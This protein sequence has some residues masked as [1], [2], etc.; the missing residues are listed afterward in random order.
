MIQ[1]FLW[2]LF[3]AWCGMILYAA[4]LVLKAFVWICQQVIKLAGKLA[5]KLEEWL[6]GDD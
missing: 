1:V 5:V 3:V 4:K 6:L 2:G